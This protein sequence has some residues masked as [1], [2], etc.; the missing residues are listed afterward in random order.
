[1]SLYPVILPLISFSPAEIFILFTVSSVPQ[2]KMFLSFLHREEDV[3]V[4]DLKPRISFNFFV[5]SPK[6]AS[7][8]IPRTDVEEA[9]RWYFTLKQAI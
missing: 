9:I 7:D 6:N 1:M 8:I 3:W 5:T 2:Q 4:S